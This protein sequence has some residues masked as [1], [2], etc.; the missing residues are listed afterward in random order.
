[1]KLFRATNK[2]TDAQTVP[3][4]SCWTSEL[5]TAEAYT[6]NPGFGGE[7]IV[8]IRIEV[9]PGDVADARGDDA[10]DIGPIAALLGLERD[11][12]QANGWDSVFCVLENSATAR[13]VLRD[14]GYRW[15]RYYDDFPE[16]ADCWVRI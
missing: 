3:S 16:N 11:T 15:V 5:E 4:G 2:P 12:L 8:E 14:A 10:R 9:E 6:D 7:H 13:G 1:M